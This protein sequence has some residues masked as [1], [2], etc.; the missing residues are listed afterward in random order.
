MMSGYV[1]SRTYDPKLP[2]LTATEFMARRFTRLYPLIFLGVLLGSAALTVRAI[3]RHDPGFAQVGV[4]TLCA[5]FVLPSF[6][7]SD[8]SIRVFDLN[9]PLWSMFFELGV[10]LIFALTFS[11]LRRPARLLG[12]VL[13]SATLLAASSIVLNQ[14][15]FGPV[16]FPLGGLRV[17][18]SFFAGVALSR[19][20]FLDALQ[21]KIPGISI[22]FLAII[23]SFILLNGQPE[24]S[25][26]YLI[27]TFLYFPLIISVA[28][29]ARQPTGVFGRILITAGIISFPV[30]AIH[31]PIIRAIYSLPVVHN[32]GELERR[33]VLAGTVC[34]TSAAAWAVAVSYDPYVKGLLSRSGWLRAHLRHVQSGN[35]DPSWR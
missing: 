32:L 19:A 13:L 21:N 27:N 23:L 4:D 3:T 9:P 25:F 34:A 2:K 30:Y 17:S 22:V 10:S 20:R 33:F 18:F 5:L 31:H 29:C 24:N 7:L 16:Y 8:Y 35:G 26:T 15:A 28:V 12:V 11:A 6:Y 14:G 1:I